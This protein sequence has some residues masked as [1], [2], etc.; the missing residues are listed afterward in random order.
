M[1]ADP[2]D[3]CFPFKLP[4]ALSQVEVHSDL[5]ETGS[6]YMSLVAFPKLLVNRVD[7]QTGQIRA[8]DVFYWLILQ[9]YVQH[10]SVQS[11]K[12]CILNG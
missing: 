4:V 3:V 12:L 11:K 1:R 8:S 6:Q 9:F 5:R 7:K 10:C 2:A